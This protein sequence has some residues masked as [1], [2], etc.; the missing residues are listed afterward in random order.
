MKLTK[1]FSAALLL[2]MSVSS[3]AGIVV[4]IHGYLGTPE[5][6][7]NSGINQHLV[8]QGW[9]RGGVIF[10]SQ[11]G[12]MLTKTAKQPEKNII[13]AVSLPSKAPL[14]VQAN[15]LHNMLGDLQKRHPDEK[16]TL[17]SHSAGGVVARLMLVRHGA[18]NID[19]LITIASPHL[20]TGLASYALSE[21]SSSGPFG[22]VKSFF[23]GETYDIA[24]SSTGLLVD[25]VP[26]RP[27][28]L[29]FWL[30][31]QPHPPIE[32]VSIVRGQDVRMNGDQIIP[33]F[34][35]DMNNVAALNSLSQ[36]YFIA[37]GHEL[38]QR[39][40]GLIELLIEADLDK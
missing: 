24:K 38:N 4:Q 39:D 17:L 34:S 32:Y 12:I 25:L 5:S 8:N 10:A 13:Y 6:W 35:Q 31:H 27:G 26:Q 22:F 30:N 18:G 20:G 23:G 33:G 14:M 36:R 37:S 15:L 28:T 1:L 21:T 40:A 3:Q 16:I 11:N 7:E 2:M 19:K 29:L 9:L